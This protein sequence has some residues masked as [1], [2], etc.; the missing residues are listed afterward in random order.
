MYSSNEP[1]EE[2]PT[3]GEKSLSSER[4]SNFFKLR[5]LRSAPISSHSCDMIE[6]ESPAH[7]GN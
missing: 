2:R 1:F 5:G 3:I 4:L 7:Q 6:E